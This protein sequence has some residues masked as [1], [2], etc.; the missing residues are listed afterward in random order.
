MPRVRSVLHAST[1]TISRGGSC[2]T[3]LSSRAAMLRASCRTVTTTLTNNG[4]DV[5]GE[6]LSSFRSRFLE[7]S[8]QGAS[9]ESRICA[10]KINE[11]ARFAVLSDDGQTKGDGHDN[12]RLPCPYRIVASGGTAFVPP[13]AGRS[14]EAIPLQPSPR[15][16]SSDGS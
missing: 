9:F 7:L 5:R 8:A 15:D 10:H 13:G 4:F 2:V 11:Q 14:E 12:H 6:R 3:R 16:A 1:T